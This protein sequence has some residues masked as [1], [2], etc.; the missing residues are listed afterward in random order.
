M[1]KS[2]G[3]TSAHGAIMV[4]FVNRGGRPGSVASGWLTDRFDRY[5]VSATSF[6]LAARSLRAVHGMQSTFRPQQALAFAWGSFIPGAHTGMNA[7]T[8]RFYPTVAHDGQNYR[9]SPSPAT[10]SRRSMPLSRPRGVS[11]PRFGTTPAARAGFNACSTLARPP[12][13]SGNCGIP[14]AK[15]GATAAASSAAIASR[16][17]RFIACLPVTAR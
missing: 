6:C 8:A 16:E 3:Y 4:G 14:R 17:R 2:A 12:S 7:P 1:G 11:P 9:A 10:P 15:A 5:R 13:S